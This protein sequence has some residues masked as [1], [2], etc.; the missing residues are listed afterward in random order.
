MSAETAT[1]TDV[2]V[3]GGGIIGAVVAFGVSAAHPDCRI[4]VL[5]RGETGTA[6]RRSLGVLAPWAGTPGQR[7]L[8]E[9]GAARLRDRALRELLRP[10]LRRV[11]VLVTGR[12]GTLDELARSTVGTRMEPAS[13]A[14]KASARAAFGELLLRQG[15][16]QASVRDGITVMDT[17]AAAAALLGAVARAGGRVRTG[18]RVT[19]I[20]EAGDGSRR[21]LLAS[22]EVVTTRR[23]VLATGPWPGPEFTTGSPLPPSWRTKRIAALRIARDLPPGAPMVCFPDDDLFVLPGRAMPTGSGAGSPGGAWASFRCEEWDVAPGDGAYPPGPR[24]VDAGRGVL[25]G[26]LPEL[27]ADALPGPAAT[28]GY[29]SDRT[30]LTDRPAPGVVRALAGSG[31]GARFCWG[32]AD[33]VLE[34]L[35]L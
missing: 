24:T 19:R 18:A 2:A 6:T 27:A 3:V 8:L 11:P 1:V 31:G 4:T 26:R 13:D 9:S 28:D 23:T 32:M 14:L 16:E 10:H 20:E 15:D 30:P 5:D 33:R 21:L 12:A 29:T 17:E 25:A 7:A 34:L 22:G 35:A